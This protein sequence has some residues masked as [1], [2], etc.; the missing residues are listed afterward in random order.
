MEN[1]EAGPLPSI[2]SQTGNRNTSQRGA[3]GIRT[4]DLLHAMQARY[5][6]RQGPMTT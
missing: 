3:C 5:Q 1:A 2:F 6:L 4:R